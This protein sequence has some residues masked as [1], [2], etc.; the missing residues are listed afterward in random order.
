MNEQTKKI[1]IIVGLVILFI[2]ITDTKKTGWPTAGTSWGTTALIGGG[3][4][5]A[6]WWA[7][8]LAAHP[9]GWIIGGGLLLLLFAGPGLISSWGNVFNPQPTIPIWVWIAGFA[10]LL[11]MVLRKK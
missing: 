10:I 6:P 5:T 9:I 3:V 11:L 2:G 1:L 7:P 8:A 4:A